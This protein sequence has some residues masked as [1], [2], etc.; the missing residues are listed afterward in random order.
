[1]SFE[2]QIIDALERFSKDLKEEA[3]NNQNAQWL[4]D[5]MVDIQKDLKKGLAGAASGFELRAFYTRAARAIGFKDLVLG[6]KS[7][8]S[9][10]EVDRLANSNEFLER[11]NVMAFPKL[12]KGKKD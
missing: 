2:T 3:P 6:P 5:Q 1:M 7:K 4:I 10:K 9:W 8:E 12:F 11:A